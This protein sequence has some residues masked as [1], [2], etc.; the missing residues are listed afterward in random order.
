MADAQVTWTAPSG[1]TLDL[2]DDSAGYMVL[3]DGTRGLRSVEYEVTSAKYAGIDGETVLALR[4]SAGQPTLGLLVYAAS[5]DDFRDRARYLRWLMRPK[6][7][8][9]TLT[10]R[11]AAG[12]AR[13]LDCYCIAGMEGDEDSALDGSW[14]KLALKFFAPDPWWRG[15]DQTVEYG[16]GTPGAFFPI[17]PITLSSS[18]VAGAFTV[19]LSMADAPS[20]PVWT[21]TGPGSSLVLTNTTT[22]KVIQVNTTLTSGQQLVIDTRPGQQSV[23]LSTGTNLMGSLAS[24]PALW[25]LVEDVN[26]VT[27][28][29]TGASSA[30]RISCTFA[31]RYAGI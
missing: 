13:A 1:A 16:L 2:T 30:S 26:A 8:L 17:F 12:E 9:G 21:I 31:P 29:L 11:N 14:W 28:S 18:T 6:A 3:G 25:P 5:E 27:V 4:A 24:D 23:R 20:Y 10:V 15:E 19:D 22:G 7:G